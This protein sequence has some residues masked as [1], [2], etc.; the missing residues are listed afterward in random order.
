MEIDRK[1]LIAIMKKQGV[2]SYEDLVI[3]MRRLNPRVS[4]PTVMRWNSEGWPQYAVNLLCDL[5]KIKE[6][7]VFKC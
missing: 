5:L 2:P 7:E 6:E 1:A 3:E 4:Y